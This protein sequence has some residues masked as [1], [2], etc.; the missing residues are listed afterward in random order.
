MGNKIII[1]RQYKNLEF[2]IYKVE[3]GV[4][5]EKGESDDYEDYCTYDKKRAYYEENTLFE[6]DYYNAL[7]Y[8]KE[9]VNNG[10]NGTYAIISK[11][12]YSTDK[13]RENIEDTLYMIQTILGG[14][15]IDNDTELFSKGELY[16]M[17][18]VVYS[19]CKKKDKDNPYFL[20]KGNGEIITNFLR[21][22]K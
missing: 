7:K 3:V 12:D 11:Y 16:N 20:G 6:L 19:L 5:W 18:Y 10:V 21:K 1:D 9:Y 17:D 8:A 13:F 14:S 4:Y 2:P 22:E 15:Y